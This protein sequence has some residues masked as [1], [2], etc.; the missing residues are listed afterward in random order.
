MRGGSNEGAPSSDELFNVNKEFSE[1]LHVDSPKDKAVNI[2]W[3]SGEELSD[4]LERKLAAAVTA[5]HN[6]N[7]FCNL[8]IRKD[9]EGPLVMNNINV[10]MDSLSSG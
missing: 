8:Q 2:V 6:G 9:D 10:S 7:R 1:A 3:V 5:E 4:R